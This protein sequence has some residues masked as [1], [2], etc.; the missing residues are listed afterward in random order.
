[1]AGDVLQMRSA[2]VQGEGRSRSAEKGGGDRQHMPSQ[3][4]V[5]SEGGWVVGCGSRVCLGEEEGGAEGV[6]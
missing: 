5:A 6:K 3:E 1:M 4:G 2:D